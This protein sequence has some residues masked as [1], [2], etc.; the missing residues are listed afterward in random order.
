[1]QP[2][3]LLN[4]RLSQLTSLVIL[5]GLT[6]VVWGLWYM[7][8]Q[9]EALADQIVAKQQMNLGEGEYRRAPSKDT[10]NAK[11]RNRS[12]NA[13]DSFDETPQNSS[14]SYPQE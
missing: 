7:M 1:M 11:N 5:L 10:K 12:I 14:P 3:A 2:Q 9:T 8:R 13:L 6:L 4:K